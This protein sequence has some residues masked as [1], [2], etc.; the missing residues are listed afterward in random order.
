LWAWIK[1]LVVPAVIAGGGIWFNR[2]QRERELEIAR[3]QRKQEIDIAER[4]TQ[5]EALQAYLDQM[6]QLETDKDQLGDNLS[7]VARART[8]SVLPR[9]GDGRRKGTVVLFLYESRLITTR[10]GPIIDLRGA[11]L[12]NLNLYLV[13]ETGFDVNRGVTM[14]ALREID[15]S[16][17]RLAGARLWNVDLNGAN[18][19]GALLWE[20][21]LTLCTLI[22]AN[23]CEASLRSSKLLSAKLSGADLSEAE[24][25]EAELSGANLSGANLSEADLSGANLSETDLS[26]ANLSNAYGWTKDQLRA[27]R[28]CE[29][30]TM[31]DGQKYE[32]WRKDR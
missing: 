15:L 32:D 30:A 5:D 1:L 7:A 12:T 20:A 22:G 23:L 19:R 10:E 2:Q 8:L 3:Q 24:L 16:R 6:S 13:G 26:G 9:L 27:A 29:G 17:T 31:P 28:S 18:L 11:D 4:R 25:N 21:D 14:A